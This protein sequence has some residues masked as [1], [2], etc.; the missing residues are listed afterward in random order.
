VTDMQAG[1]PPRTLHDLIR[2]QI[3]VNKSLGFVLVAAFLVNAGLIAVIVAAFVGPIGLLLTALLLLGAVGWA[4]MKFRA[5]AR[6]DTDM[7]VLL[8]GEAARLAPIVARVCQTLAIPVPALRIMPE[9]DVLNACSWSVGSQ[10][11][12]AYTTGLLG[13]LNDEE[14]EAVTAHEAGHIVSRDSRMYQ[15]AY[16]GLAWAKLMTRIFAVFTAFL[17]ALGVH[18]AFTD[19]DTDD[20]DPADAVANF[21]SG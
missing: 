20:G 13:A 15:F 6:T 2:S 19:I 9:H 8:P 7:R 18:F 4:A 5:A 17:V 14:L 21:F 10:A 3:N 1:P 16:A 12:I 11:S